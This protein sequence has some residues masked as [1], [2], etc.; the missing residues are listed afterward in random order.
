MPRR[1]YELTKK[2]REDLFATYR[3]VCASG[4]HTQLEAWKKTLSHPAPRYYVTPKR[5]YMVLCDMVKGD[6][7]KVD[8]IQENKRRMFYSMY[9]KLLEL[10]QLPQFM[11]KS[12]WFICQFLVSQPA[13]EFYLTP[14]ALA[15]IFSNC[16][17][18]GIAYKY[19]EV[20]EDKR[21]KHRS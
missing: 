1:D 11:G 13:P 5:A 9:D 3:E 16:R 12:L 17:R 7:T 20:Y 19:Y 6:F 10:S 15:M 14:N 4:C 8:A 18:H 21:K 2:L